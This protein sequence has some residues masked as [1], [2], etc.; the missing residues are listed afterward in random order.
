MDFIGIFLFTLSLSILLV[1][2]VQ[3]STQLNIETYQKNTI[4]INSNATYYSLE[5]N[6]SSNS[7]IR[8]T[9]NNTPDYWNISNG[10][11][12]TV[13]GNY[14]I[15]YVGTFRYFAGSSIGYFPSLGQ[16]LGLQFILHGDTSMVDTYAV[17]L[18]NVKTNST[19]AG[20]AVGYDF[21]QSYI[22]QNTYV[23]ITPK[24]GV[25]S[26]VETGTYKIYLGFYI[27]QYGIGLSNLSTYQA[28]YGVQQAET[29][30]ILSP[31]APASAMSGWNYNES[32]V[33]FNLSYPSNTVAFQFDYHSPY[34]ISLDSNLPVRNFT[35]N[36][37]NLLPSG[38]IFH[39]IVGNPS[40]PSFTVNWTMNYLV[41]TDYENYDSK[42]SSTIVHI[43]T[44]FDAN[45]TGILHLESYWLN[46]QN[47]DGKHWDTSFNLV[48]KHLLVSG[49]EFNSTYNAFYV[50]GI[51]INNPREY[52]DYTFSLFVNSKIDNNVSVT[53]VTNDYTNIGSN[54]NATKNLTSPDFKI[55]ILEYIGLASG[56]S[57]FL[58][59]I[60]VY[61]FF[62]RKG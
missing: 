1:P 40:T 47:I 41:T 24:W 32:Y 51:L 61:I 23:Q 58:S 19:V 29:S 57:A 62:K 16:N 38:G 25:M 15:F 4:D 60:M 27:G 53:I 2:I 37:T 18:N 42:V 26:G 17:F 48:V 7:T 10:S 43:G 46:G 31:Q 56:V 11:S 45:Y 22:T 21:S 55:P 54:N 12:T 6:I 3:A 13:A 8:A 34:N 50:N 44:S 49:I 14:L 5:P 9:E 39:N 52:T 28:N 35:E 33:S 59:G 36:Y 20:Y 30:N